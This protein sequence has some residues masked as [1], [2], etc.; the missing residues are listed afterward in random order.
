MHPMIR[1][2]GG[3]MPIAMEEYSKKMQQESPEGGFFAV[4]KG[5]NLCMQS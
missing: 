4:G 5:E 1:R 2:T 3:H